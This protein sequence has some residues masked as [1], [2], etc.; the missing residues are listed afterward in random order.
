MGKRATGAQGAVQRELAGWKQDRQTHRQ[1]G[2]DVGQMQRRQH[3]VQASVERRGAQAAFQ[4]D[5]A[6]LVQLAAEGQG[7]GIA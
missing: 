7:G 5:P 6:T 2:Q 3:Q 4:A 1:P